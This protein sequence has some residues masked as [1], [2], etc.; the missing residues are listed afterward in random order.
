MSPSEYQ[1]LVAFLGE[2]F[3]AID[4]RFEAMDQRFDELRAEILGHFGE[5]YRRP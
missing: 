1:D 3:K 5:L 4:Q 2:R